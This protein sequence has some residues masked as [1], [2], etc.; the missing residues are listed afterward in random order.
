[1]GDE[2]SLTARL[3]ELGASRS[4]CFEGLLAVFRGAISRSQQDGGLEVI[5]RYS[6]SFHRGRS[7]VRRFGRL[8]PKVK[9]S[10]SRPPL[11]S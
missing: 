11:H 5:G 4:F 6:A 3:T 1:M 8:Q 10:Q 9:L 7:L 2:H